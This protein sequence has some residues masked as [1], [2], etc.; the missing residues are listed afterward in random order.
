MLLGGEECYHIHQCIQ[1]L[2]PQEDIV[3]HMQLSDR[4]RILIT[5]CDITTS[6]T[7]T[8]SSGKDTLSFSSIMLNRASSRLV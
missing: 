4:K 6:I 8:L 5:Y 7:I 3:L 1:C 2:L